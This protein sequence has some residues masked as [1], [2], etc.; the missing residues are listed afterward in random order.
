MQARGCFQTHPPPLR[1]E[2][3]K[4]MDGW[5][6]VRGVGVGLRSYSLKPPL[7]APSLSLCVLSRCVLS[8]LNFLSLSLSLSVLRSIC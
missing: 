4:M 1:E 2:G 6:S 8:V 5:T 7:Y 3:W